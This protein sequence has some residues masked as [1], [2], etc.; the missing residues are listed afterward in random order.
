MLLNPQSKP[1][2]TKNRNRK[3]PLSQASLLPVK[4]QW[5]A[6]FLKSSQKE[7]Q[8][9]AIFHHKGR[10]MRLLAG[11]DTFGAQKI[12]AIFHLR[13]NLSDMFRRSA[14]LAI[15]HHKGFAAILSLSLSSLDT[16][17]AASNCHTNRSVKLPS[18]RHFQDRFLTTNKEK[19]GKKNGPVFRK[20]CVFDVSRAVGIARFESVSEAHLHRTIQCH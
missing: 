18:F 6:F 13:Q 11:Q 15:P 20:V 4:P 9:L 5:D 17:I 10:I 19:W 7:S 2:S 14:S 1:E 3:S 12:A 8:S 16:R